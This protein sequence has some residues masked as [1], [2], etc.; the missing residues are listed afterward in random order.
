MKGRR[1]P[2]NPA[3][4]SVMASRNGNSLGTPASLPARLSFADGANIANERRRPSTSSQPLPAMPSHP[5]ITQ[6]IAHTSR[7]AAEEA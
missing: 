4:T 3:G 7:R 1:N 5:Q 6:N 2:T